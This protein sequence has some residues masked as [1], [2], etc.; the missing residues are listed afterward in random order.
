MDKTEFVTDFIKG[1]RELM[2]EKAVMI[3]SNTST[4]T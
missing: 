4:I 2:L 3:K 1:Y